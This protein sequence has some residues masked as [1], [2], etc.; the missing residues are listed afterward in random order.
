MQDRR[1]LMSPQQPP[2]PGAI[3]P[4]LDRS[5]QPAAQ[6]VQLGPQ[7]LDSLE[8]KLAVQRSMC[9]AVLPVKLSALLPCAVAP[10]LNYTNTAQVSY[11][12]T[13]GQYRFSPICTD[14]MKN[15]RP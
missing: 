7:R 2:R 6:P 12:L 15:P 3:L 1:P 8:A 13:F 5:A 10:C 14:C 11:D 4:S 9:N